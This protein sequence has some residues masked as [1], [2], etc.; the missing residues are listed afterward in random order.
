LSAIST[1]ELVVG[2][3]A[4]E[5]IGDS[6]PTSY[7]THYLIQEIQS[8]AL[9]ISWERN[10][11]RHLFHKDFKLPPPHWMVPLLSA[12]CFPAAAPSQFCLALVC[13]PRFRLFSIDS[14]NK[15]RR[16]PALREYFLLI[17]M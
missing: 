4:Y 14:D 10:E 5:Q 15:R 9:G 2:K 12:I 6:I 8:T 1:A 16:P 3:Q 17:A 11:K 13:G 7:S